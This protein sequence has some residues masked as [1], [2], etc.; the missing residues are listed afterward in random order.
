MIVPIYINLEN[1]V[2]VVSD[3]LQCCFLFL[4]AKGTTS[5]RTVRMHIEM[6]HHNNFCSLCYVLINCPDEFPL[7]ISQ[8]NVSHFL[9]NK[10]CN[11]H[12]NQKHHG[13]VLCVTVN[14]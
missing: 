11:L 2:S 3:P 8:A 14:F 13:I 4:I 5:I 12:K 7:K 6:R 1:N 10:V 9:M